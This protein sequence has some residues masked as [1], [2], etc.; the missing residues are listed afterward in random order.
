MSF[1]RAF[2]TSFISLVDD[3]LKMSRQPDMSK[4]IRVELLTMK[5]LLTMMVATRP[6]ELRNSFLASVHTYHRQIIEKDESFFLANSDH[7]GDDAVGSK[8]EL[9]KTL[10]KSGALTPDNKRRI[11]S[12][13]S[14]LLR[15]A[16]CSTDD[17]Q[18]DDVRAYMKESSK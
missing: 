11:W 8:V 5:T 15:L 18:Y 9:V 12:G 14:V 6:D 16:I 2:G 13:M 3:M 17:K 7:C 10:W 1:I 4:S